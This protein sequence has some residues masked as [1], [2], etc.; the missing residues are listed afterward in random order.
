MSLRPERV[1]PTLE[2]MWDYWRADGSPTVSAWLASQHGVR[3]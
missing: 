3:P 1:Q 2:R